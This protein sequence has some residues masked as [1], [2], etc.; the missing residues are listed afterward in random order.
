MV[1]CL[2]LP[3]LAGQWCGLFGYQSAPLARHK[4][5]S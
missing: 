4:K 5:N 1:G 2:A 3:V